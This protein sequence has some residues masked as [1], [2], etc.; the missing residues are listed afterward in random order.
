MKVNYFYIYMVL[1]LEIV[2]FMMKVNF[3]LLKVSE[4]E[5]MT[6]VV[7]YVH[8]IIIKIILS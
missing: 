4:F 5:M 7:F 6:N 1:L 2:I 8:L 3:L